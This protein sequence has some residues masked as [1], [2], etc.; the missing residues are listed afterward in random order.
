MKFSINN[1]LLRQETESDF[2]TTE[3][4]V[5]I[6]F[7][8]MPFADGN[9]HLLVKRM[10]SN[11]NYIPELSLVAIVNNQLVGHILFSVIKI[12]G[13]TEYESLALA[14]VSV[15]PGFQKKGIGKLLVQKGLTIAKEM[16]FESVVVVGHAD[17]YPKFG[18]EK[19]SKW[20]IYNPIEVPD[21]ASMALELK[22]DSLKDKPGI[23]EYPVEFGL[24]DHK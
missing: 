14:P 9:E 19:A 1:I 6:A 17:Y 24:G 15:L 11:K 10:R 22:Q 7:K 21:E 2:Q 4:I 20:G 23:I 12:K 18:F 16:G 5:E 8:T 13:E 3:K